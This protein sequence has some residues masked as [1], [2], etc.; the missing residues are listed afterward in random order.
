MID[1]EETFSNVP[2]SRTPCGIVVEFQR[3][4]YFKVCLSDGQEI[5][6]VM[7][8]R[9]LAK[10]MAIYDRRPGHYLSV[11]VQLNRPPRMHRIVRTSVSVLS[12]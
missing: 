5:V 3:R 2:K 9:L 10:A 11:E 7:P 12:C 8:E 1:K 4:N 6:A